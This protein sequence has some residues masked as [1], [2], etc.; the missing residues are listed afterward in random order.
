MAQWRAFAAIGSAA[1]AAS[2]LACTAAPAR[3]TGSGGLSAV[4]SASPSPADSPSPEPPSPTPAAITTT[5]LPPP[6]TPTIVPLKPLQCPTV[7]GKPQTAAHVRELLTTASHHNIYVDSHQDPSV[8]D[9]RLNGVL[10]NV[11]IPLSMLKAVA[12]IES[13]WTSTCVSSDGNNGYGVMQMDDAATAFV[14]QHFQTSFTKTDQDTNVLLGNA[15]LE[16]LTVRFGV[17]YFHNDF[18]LS[19]NK[20]L[21]DAVLAAYN[22]G[23]AIVDGGAGAGIH[24]GPVGTQY[25]AD[26]T[27]LMHNRTVQTKWGY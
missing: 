15:Y 6:P 20:P 19:T 12:A 24:I 26:V 17:E 25:A 27:A 5:T 2:L 7:T 14:N 4:A 23:L 1:L 10:P 11:H 16:Y 18:N 9:K 3:T 13:S 22:T 21:R 8:L